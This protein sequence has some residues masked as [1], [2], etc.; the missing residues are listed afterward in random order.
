[1]CVLLVFMYIQL[2][3]RYMCTVTHHFISLAGFGTSHNDKV[4]V[5]E[6]LDNYESNPMAQ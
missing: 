5:F 4:L 6:D 3:G 1:M 2:V